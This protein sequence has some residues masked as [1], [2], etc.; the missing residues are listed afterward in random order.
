MVPTR[1]KVAMAR[2]SWSASD[3]VKPAAT[4]AIFI[5]CS[6]NSGTPSVLSQHRFQLLRRIG[7]RLLAAAAAQIGMH[8]VALDRA[9]AHD[10]DFDDQVVEVLRLEPRQHGH[11]RA[12]FDLEHA[13]RI[14]AVEHVVDGRFLGGDGGEGQIARRIA[15]PTKIERLADA[16]QHAEAEHVDLENAERVEIVLVPFDE[17]AVVHGAIADRHHLVE[18]AAR[19]DE[20]ADVLREMAREADDLVRPAPRSGACARLC[21]IEPGAREIVLRDI[22]AA[23]AP[24]RGRQRA[25]GVFGQAEGLADLA[26]R[27]AAAIGDDGGGDAGALAAVFAVDVLDHLLAPLVLEIDVDVGRLAPLRRDEALEQQIGAVGIDLGD[28][29]AEADRGIGR[30]AAALAEDALRAGEAHDVVDGEEVGRVSELRDQRQFVLD[31]GAHLVGQ[32]V[33]IALGGAFVGEMRQRLL[34]VRKAVDALV[35]IF[36]AQ[37]VEREGERLAQAQRLLDRLRRVAE[38]PR[39]FLA[40]VSESARHWR[41][42]CARRGR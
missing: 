23:A 24:D 2:R 37:L 30:R 10:R 28:A 22:A 19:D 34:R 15:F 7:D 20:A 40:A 1:L 12:A 27:R 9:G 18:P 14:G 16:G 35:G 41:R 6:W 33:R 5:A 13:E 8:H 29:E 4:M 32:A 31:C 3:G 36:V 26:D 21:R 42:A 38:Q 39:H 17:G 25:D 11:L